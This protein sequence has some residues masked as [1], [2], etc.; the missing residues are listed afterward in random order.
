MGRS[1]SRLLAG[2]ALVLMATGAR[3][4]EPGP[5]ET[6]PTTE[7]DPGTDR[8]WT[9]QRLVERAESRSLQV[10]VSQ[11]EVDE[12]RALYELAAAQSLPRG[13]LSTIVGGP[14]PEAQTR[15]QNDISTVTEASLGNDLNFGELGVT[16]RGNARFLQ[17]LYGFGRIRSAKRATGNLVEAAEAQKEATTAEVVLNVYRAFWT[18]QLVREFVRALEE[19]QD[20]LQQVVDQLEELLDAESGQVTEN[21][22]LRVNYALSTVR[23]RLAEARIGSERANQA[24]RILVDAPLGEP[25]SVA[26]EDLWD[27]VPERAPDLDGLVRGVREERPELQALRRVVKAQA[28]FVE[29]RRANLLPNFFAGVLVEWAYTSNATDQTNPFIFDPFNLFDLGLGVGLV[30]EL[31]VFSK[32]AQLEQ[33]KAQHATRVQQQALATRAAELEVRQLHAQMSGGFE[34]LVQLEDANRAARGWL[35]STVLAFEIGAGDAAELIDAFVA[36]A[37]SEAELQSVRYNLILRRAELARSV[38]RLRGL[39]AGS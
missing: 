33:A 11:A 12:A 29:L 28:D 26:R 10:R 16:I 25:L 22:R 24:L 38:G 31:D 14:V 37:A 27:G 5:G 9:L 21:D 19:G 13:E 3:A 1:R 15:I 6:T 23:V 7:S 39:N 30:W 18:L 17:P 2:A 8:A 36:F 4:G 20:T 34:Q 32:L 35:T